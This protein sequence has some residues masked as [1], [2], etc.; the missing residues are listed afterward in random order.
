MNAFQTRGYL[1]I[2]GEENY[3]GTSVVRKY[4]KDK[5]FYAI[6]EI[7]DDSDYPMEKIDNEISIMLSLKHPNI[8]E[9]KEWFISQ[10]EMNVYKCLVMEW[11]EDSLQH[12]VN[13]N[14]YGLSIDEMHFF[15]S[16]MMNA[17]K[18]L[19]LEKK[20]LHRDLKLANF[21][22]KRSKEYPFPIV[23]L[24]DFGSAISITPKISGSFSSLL[25]SAPEVNKEE[26]TSKID[27]WSLGCCIYWMA[28]GHP[29]YP[30]DDVNEFHTSLEKEEPIQFN[31]IPDGSLKSMLTQMLVFDSEQRISWE[32][33]FNTL[34]VEECH[35]EKIDVEGSKENYQIINELGKGSFGSVVKAWDKRNQKY[36]AIKK[37]YRNDIDNS[38]LKQMA[39]K[40]IRIMKLFHH[41]NICAFFDYYVDVQCYLVMEYCDSGDIQQLIDIRRRQGANPLLSNEEIFSFTNDILNGIKY[42]HVEKHFAHRDIKPSNILLAHSLISKYPVVKISDLGLTKRDNYIDPLRTN[43]GT[44]AYMAP[45]IH[46][47]NYTYQSDLWSIGCVIY[48]MCTGSLIFPKNNFRLFFS[49]KRLPP[50]GSLK[51]KPS[52]IDLMKHLIVYDVN[53]RWGWKEIETS[54]FM[55]E[56]NGENVKLIHQIEEEAQV[57]DD[58]VKDGKNTIEVVTKMK[59]N[60]K[61]MSVEE[62]MGVLYTIGKLCNISI[63]ES[64]C[65]INVNVH[66][67]MTLFECTRDITFEAL[68]MMETCPTDKDWKL[69]LNYSR[70]MFRVLN[71]LLPSTEQKYIHQSLFSFLYIIKYKKKIN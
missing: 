64:P 18:Y 25:F 37:I 28:T 9:L 65:D 7:K 32:K 61:Q 11:C 48:Y 4:K 13:R 59:M 40:E 3:G 67:I 8:I 12:Y 54:P 50:F 34:F 43:A 70:S 45:E 42:L 56:Y 49:E 63:E 41:P 47:G 60:I 2:S 29:I 39:M 35:K 51:V 21:L 17:L 58:M 62:M 53:K 71:K 10:N 38:L 15:V 22:L 52:I 23:K 36:V 66:P 33:L 1:L 24:C 69:L 19:V 31:E 20:I 55:Y 14:S 68:N 46:N 30:I 27:I 57:E 5:L 44:P 16:D 26:Y 6:K